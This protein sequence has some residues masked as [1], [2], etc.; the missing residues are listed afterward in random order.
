MHYI[1]PEMLNESTTSDG[2][3]ADVYSLAKLLWKLCTGQTFPLPGVQSRDHRALN[4]S[5]YI[6]DGR[7]HTLDALIEGATQFEPHSRPP[8]AA[9]AQSLAGWFDP[10]PAPKGPLDLMPLKS[11]VANLME[12]VQ[13]E[14]RRRERLAEQAHREISGFFWP[15]RSILGDIFSSL[16]G[17]GIYDIHL[18]EVEG[19][20]NHFCSHRGAERDSFFE[21]SVIAV[22]R[23]DRKRASVM[24]GV[25]LGLRNLSGGTT[26]DILWPVLGAAGYLLELHVFDGSTWQDTSKLLWALGEV[27]LLGGP[28]SA[29]AQARFSAGLIENLYPSVEALLAAY[30]EGS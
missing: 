15:F 21:Y 28:D 2:R 27:F 3:A 20:N 9:V 30:D 23:S 19:G 18:N 7:A 12:P 13:S 14:E 24:A 25:N 6:R 4:V 22:L 1:A 8:M 10:V 26:P 17:A 11:A 16:Q 29:A 5:G